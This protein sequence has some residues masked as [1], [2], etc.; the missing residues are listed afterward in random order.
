MFNNFS[1]D[2]R[3]Q[4]VEI[5]SRLATANV[6]QFFFFNEIE[7]YVIHNYKIFEA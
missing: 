3:E 2:N 5:A 6:K 4:N 1:T 7:K